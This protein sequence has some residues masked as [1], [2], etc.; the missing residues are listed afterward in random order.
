MPR[1]GTH[2]P[3]SVLS[4]THDIESRW[5]PFVVAFLH[6]PLWRRRRTMLSVRIKRLLLST[7]RWSTIGHRVILWPALGAS[8]D[9]T[10]NFR[11]P[12]V[13]TWSQSDKQTLA[14]SRWPLHV[15]WASYAKPP[16]ENR[17]KTSMLELDQT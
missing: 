17:R 5:V 3:S 1:H 16:A 4:F 12:T 8:R 14:A 6:Y 10:T 7:P 13:A 11:P 9:E 2:S 15:R